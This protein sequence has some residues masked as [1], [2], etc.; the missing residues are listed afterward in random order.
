M[1]VTGFRSEDAGFFEVDTVVCVFGM[2]GYRVAVSSERWDVVLVLPQSFFEILGPAD[3]TGV[4]IGTRNF[5]DIALGF[6]F[7]WPV[8]G[9]R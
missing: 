4:A 9:N 5:V 1:A 8:F 3:I 2:L 7:R 6:F